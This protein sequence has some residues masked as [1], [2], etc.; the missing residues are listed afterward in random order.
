MQLPEPCGRFPVSLYIVCDE[1]EFLQIEDK[2]A[3]ASPIRQ[4]LA[5]PMSHLKL[6]SLATDTFTKP[7]LKL[8]PWSFS[9]ERA[10]D[11]QQ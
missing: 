3:G 1:I 10:G 8:D 2:E 11:S 6:S 5:W 9:R 4:S 7:A